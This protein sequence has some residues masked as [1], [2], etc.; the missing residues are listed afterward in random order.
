MLHVLLQLR[1]LHSCKKIHINFTI[2]SWN[3]TY[4]NYV[5]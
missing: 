1:F 5:A 4:S 2:N 3:G